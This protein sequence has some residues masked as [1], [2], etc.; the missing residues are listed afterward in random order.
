M[1]VRVI[2]QRVAQFASAG[3]KPSWFRQPSEVVVASERIIG[4][5]W[6]PADPCDVVPTDDVTFLSH[7]R[8]GGLGLIQWQ[9]PT[10]QNQTE[11]EATMSDDTT[12]RLRDTI[13]VD[14]RPLAMWTRLSGRASRT[15]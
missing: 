5:A 9:V 15:R 14:E 8:R 7:L 2:D 1:L 3:V 12:K 11:E 10:N 6:C 13:Q 4:G